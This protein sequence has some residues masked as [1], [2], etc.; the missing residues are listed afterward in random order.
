MTVLE[1]AAFATPS[2]LDGGG[3]VGALSRLR[4]GDHGEALTANF[5]T[6]PI[7]DTAATIVALLERDHES[8]QR[9]TGSGVLNA[10]GAR[11]R[12]RALAWDMRTFGRGLA[13]AVVG[14]NKL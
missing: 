10:T 12:E 14:E 3:G 9:A 11:A 6:G 2:L 4:P 5:G 1:A 13:D 7:E 8:E